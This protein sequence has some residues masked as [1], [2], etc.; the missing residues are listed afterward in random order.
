MKQLYKNP[1]FE[2][3]TLNSPRTH[4]NVKTRCPGISIIRKI[5]EGY[6]TLEYEQ[7]FD[8]WVVGDMQSDPYLREFQSVS[9]SPDKKGLVA[10]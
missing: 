3:I 5:A 9:I 1:R 2:V 4:G 7:E 8:T 6:P 10:N